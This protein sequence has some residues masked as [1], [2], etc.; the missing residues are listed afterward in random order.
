K[1]GLIAGR[2]NFPLLFAQEAK[3]QHSSVIAVAVKGETKRQLKKYVEKIYWINVWQ[4]NKIL[5]IFKKETLEEIA[6]A[7]QI[8]PLYLFNKKVMTNPA[9]LSIL[10]KI[11]DRKADTIFGAVAAELEAVGFKLVDSTLFL[12]DYLPK[13][14][15]LTA[16]QPSFGLWEDIYFG[17]EVAKYIAALDIGQTVAVK[18]KT[19]VAVEALEG[20][21]VT[22][23]RAA[24]ITGGGIVV[25]K[26]SKPKQDMR[27][28]I[29]VVGL[30]TIKNLINAR[31]SCLAIEAE[32]TLFLDR[33]VSLR[34][35]NSNNICIVSV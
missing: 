21:D 34:L 9:F 28:D 2:G 18:D 24:R 33:D 20:T 14:G 15:V 16:Q 25:V 10:N 7:G 27:F 26:V 11:K 17:W 4:F 3:K 32:K 23:Q 1:I 12:K 29:P 19:V 22:I 6:M 8:N 30:K 5:E 31:A 35:A 13:K